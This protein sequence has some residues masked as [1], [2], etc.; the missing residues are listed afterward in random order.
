MGRFR[1]GEEEHYGGTG[2]A[3][4]F[5]LKNDKDVAVVR[6]M[7]DSVDDVDGY[8]VHQVEIDGR[9]RYVNCLREYSD[10]IDVC[11]FCRAKMFQVAKLFIPL[12]NVDTGNVQV[13]DRGKRFFSRMT[14]LCARYPH[15]VSHTFEIERHGKAGSADTTYEIYE[16]GQDETT[17]EDLPE[18]PKVLGGIVLDKTAE[19]MEA[20]LKDGNFPSGTEEEIRPR[21]TSTS[22]TEL[23]RRTPTSTRRDAF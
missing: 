11:P 15:T 6:F 21:R 9:N 18:I 20:Y 23:P 16:T 17:L 4:F 7:Y 13:W 1:A 8:A 3:G 5:S 14:G 10:P 2:G 22:S 19:E 12:Y